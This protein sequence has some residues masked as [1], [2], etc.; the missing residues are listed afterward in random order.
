MF[1]SKIWY[2]RWKQKILSLLEKKNI[3]HIILWIMNRNLYLKFDQDLENV[4]KNLYKK[5]S[6]LYTLDN[7]KVLNFLEWSAYLSIQWL[8]SI[9]PIWREQVQAEPCTW[10]EVN[11]SWTIEGGDAAS[12]LQF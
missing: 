4:N 7:Y 12:A 10:L 3:F 9:Q 8:N 1:N 6:K 5:I 2:I 11:P